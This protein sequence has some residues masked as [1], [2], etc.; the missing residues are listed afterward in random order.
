MQNEYI[1]LHAGETYAENEVKV[2]GKEELLGAEEAVLRWRPV[3][4]SWLT[5]GSSK[6]QCCC[7]KRWKE[8]LLLF[9]SPLVCRF[10]FFSFIVKCF[11]FCTPCSPVYFFSNPPMFQTRLLSSLSLSLSLSLSAAFLFFSSHFLFVPFLFFVLLLSGVES[12]IYRAKG[13]EGVPIAALSLCMG[14]GAFLP[15]HDAELGGQ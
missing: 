4:V 14:S 5:H 6:Q 3:A 15:C 9:P 2:E 13:S 10:S 1:V 11:P 12:S 8:R 7:F